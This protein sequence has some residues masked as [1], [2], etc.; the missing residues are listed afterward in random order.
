LDLI[1]EVRRD[2]QISFEELGKKI[3]IPDSGTLSNFFNRKRNMKI[4]KSMAKKIY[5]TLNRD[6]RLLNFAHFECSGDQEWYVLILPVGR[7][8]VSLED[9]LNNE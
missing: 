9:E 8:K 2:Y 5:E 6:S 1:D 4:G 7:L 3:G